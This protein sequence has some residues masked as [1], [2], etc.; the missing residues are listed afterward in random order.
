MVHD[1]LA[2]PP[3][4]SV[5]LAGLSEMVMTHDPEVVKVY[6]VAV[7]TDDLH[8]AWIDGGQPGTWKNVQRGFVAWRAKQ[9]S[10]A[11]AGPSMDLRWQ[12]VRSSVTD[13]SA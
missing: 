3:S 9:P 8:K 10:S 6:R 7:E 12:P 4:C 11:A 2:N 1:A 5:S 13:M